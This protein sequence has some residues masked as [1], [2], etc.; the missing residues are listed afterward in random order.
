[1]AGFD[2]TKDEVVREVVVPAEDEDER[3][4]VKLVR[5]NEGPEKIQISRFKQSGDERKYLKLKRL[6]VE[7]ARQ[8]RD[9]ITELI[10]E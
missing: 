9:A 1:M 10:G 3:I 2:P 8:V 5:Y 7:E 6:F 4:E